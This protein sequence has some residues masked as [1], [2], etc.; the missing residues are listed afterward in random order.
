VARGAIGNPWIFG[1]AKAL[2]AGLPCPEPDLAEQRRVLKLQCELSLES[3]DAA[4]ALSSLRAFGVKFARLHPQHEDVRNDFAR[5]KKL[6]DWVAVIDRWYG[7]Y[8]T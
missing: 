4:Q 6:E 2:A 7:A 8:F 3:S 5:T 1:Q